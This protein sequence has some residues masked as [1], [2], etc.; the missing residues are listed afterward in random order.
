MEHVSRY[1]VF[2]K[3]SI[4]FSRPMLIG[5]VVCEVLYSG[6]LFALKV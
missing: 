2:I 1:T 3:F 4:P 5:Y 6:F